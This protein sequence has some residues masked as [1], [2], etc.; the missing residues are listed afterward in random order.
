MAV[1]VYTARKKDGSTYYRANISYRGHHISLGSS[2]NEDE[3]ALVYLQAKEFT[4]V[5]ADET[6][7]P[8]NI[9]AATEM[10]VNVLKCYPAVSFE[11]L[12]TMVNLRDN[13]IYIGNPIYLLSGFFLYFLTPR[14]ILKFDRDDLFYYSN[15]RIMRRGGHLFVNDFGMQVSLLDRYGVRSHGV[16]GIDYRFSNGDEFDYRYENIEVINPWHG[17]SL[18]RDEESGAMTYRVRIHIEGYWSIGVYQDAITAAVAYNKAVDMAHAFGIDKNY[19][20][21]YIV[22]LPAKRYTEIYAGVE[23][24]K[25]FLRYLRRL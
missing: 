24:S 11:K 15:H 4:A 19:A 9:A 3:A 12:I 25:R 23:I 5:P 13:G 17:V 22:D 10:I 6:E 18:V 14:D 20:T 21:N 16:N 2:V 1:G 8:A 7:L